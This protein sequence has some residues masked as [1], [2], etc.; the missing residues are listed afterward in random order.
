[1][2]KFNLTPEAIYKQYRQTRLEDVAHSAAQTT[3]TGS[4]A[5]QVYRRYRQTRSS[6]REVRIDA[7][8][9]NLSISET[10]TAHIAGNSLQDTP[11]LT[12]H[13][14]KLLTMLGM[15]GR[16]LDKL[17]SLPTSIRYAVPAVAA[18][19]LAVFLLPGVFNNTKHQTALPPAAFISNAETL[20]DYI[21]SPKAVSLGLSGQSDNTRTAFNRGALSVDVALAFNADDPSILISVLDNIISTHNSN[22]Q[23][24]L[25]SAATRLGAAVTAHAD[26]SQKQSQTESI[27]DLHLKLQTELSD[28]PAEAESDRWF[29][30]GQSTESTLIASQHALNTSNSTILQQTLIAGSELDINGLN[31]PSLKLIKEIQGFAHKQLQNQAQIREILANAQN[32]KLLM[33]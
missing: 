27:Q 31:H 23:T 32:I 25:V 13:R 11:Q 5:E 19:L 14:S 12:R 29:A 18:G 4:I 26:S 24:E 7:I 30:L 2:S 33:Q 9:S 21:D 8:M 3:S 15:P 22:G 17:V 10:S 16:V 28:Y 6:D 20:A 1:M